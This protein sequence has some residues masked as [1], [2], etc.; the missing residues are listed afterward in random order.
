MQQ[1]TKDQ[2]H[3]VWSALTKEATNGTLGITISLEKDKPDLRIRILLALIMC[4]SLFVLP[5]EAHEASPT[6]GAQASVCLLET[7]RHVDT[8]ASTIPISFFVA[9]FEESG[10]DVREYTISTLG[11]ATRGQGHWRALV[12]PQGFSEKGD[13][14]SAWAVYSDQTKRQT[15]SK[16]L[17]D[18]AAA[19]LSSSTGS[20]DTISGEI[21]A[22]K[23][24]KPG[25]RIPYTVQ[26]VLDSG[27]TIQ[28]VGV[29]VVQTATA[30][31]G[32]ING[33]C[34]I[35]TSYSDGVFA[36]IPSVHNLANSAGYEFVYATDHI[37]MIRDTSLNHSW[38]DYVSQLK[39]ASTSVT[40]A[41]GLEVTCADS[42][43]DGTYDGDCLGYGLPTTSDPTLIQ[44]WMDGCS[45][46]VFDIQY[47]SG[48]TACVA[49]PAVSAPVIN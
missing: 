11:D 30:P 47:Y 5:G 2:V 29:V 46:T 44:N 25:D 40:M 37:D 9:D 23:G 14:D 15:G 39:T 48:A 32:W 28:A 38:L 27:E 31:T 24:A 6:K 35:H 16:D 41:P 21:P 12:K 26:A 20:F 19:I 13:F 3:R 36:S 34:H 33:E 49:H 22:P 1:E 17:N 8:S 45:D 10:R 7:Q 42:D 4:F 18:K 43:F